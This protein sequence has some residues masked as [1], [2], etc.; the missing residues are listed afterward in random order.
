MELNRSSNQH[1]TYNI[2]RFIASTV[3]GV[4]YWLNRTTRLGS[5]IALSKR[6]FIASMD[7]Y[8]FAGLLHIDIHERQIS[9]TQSSR[10]HT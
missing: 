10:M 3:S 8:Y 9:Y 5:L 6:T 7:A 1:H 2:S 4:A